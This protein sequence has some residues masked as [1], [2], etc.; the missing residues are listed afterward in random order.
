MSA[1]KEGHITAGGNRLEGQKF[2]YETK[3][4][5][6]Q[7]QAI[8][9]GTAQLPNP[10]DPVNMP[11]GST[12]VFKGQKYQ[13]TAFEASYKH[14]AAEAKMTD[15][16]GAGMSV[17]KLENNKV[18]ISSGPVNAVESEVYAGLKSKELALGLKAKQTE[19]RTHMKV[20]ELDLNTQE[21]QDRYHRFL[22]TGE[23]P[24]ADGDTVS[25]SGTVETHKISNEASAQLSIGPVDINA[26]LR[27]DEGERKVT[28]YTDGSK[29]EEISLTY[30]QGNNL[31]I[32]KDFD[33]RGTSVP[34]SHKPNPTYT[35]TLG[36][37]DPRSAYQ[38]E[39]A[40]AQDVAAAE[41]KD[42]RNNPTQDAQISFSPEDALEMK[43]MATEYVHKH[44][45][46]SNTSLQDAVLHGT[47]ATM[48]QLA[49]ARNAD[50][51]AAVL[52]KS[53]S[54]GRL[55]E[56]LAMLQSENADKPLPGNQPKFQPS[57]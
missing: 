51:V 14:I 18:R 4:S 21:G 8:R 19:E 34:D 17:E 15:F 3:V 11:E 45:D 32:S 6:E 28:Q 40:F 2:T 5:K 52:A 24:Q 47:S 42:Y 33:F 29:S 22:L 12:A 56:D 30:G 39:A 54:N 9:D 7:E 16:R 37:V 43:R 50:E 55:A 41:A 25:R 31:T 46:L 48:Q 53:A 20:A 38:L 57:P 10:F 26:Q 27:A 36:K 49:L 23:V 35:L 1:G 13:G 44:N